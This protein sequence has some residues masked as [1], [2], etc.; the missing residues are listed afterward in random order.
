MFR[1]AASEF[2]YVRTYSRWL[3]EQGRRENWPETVDRFVNFIVEERGALIPPKVLRK[4][5]QKILNF[6]VMP[7]MRALWA[8]G[9]AAKQ[10]NVCMYNC[11]ALAVDS[12]DAFA[13]T[14]YI[15][16]CG[17][18]L[19]YSVQ[20]K[21]ISKLPEI[22][23]IGFETL[24]RHIVEDSKDGWSESIRLLMSSLYEGKDIEFDYTSIRPAG[25]KLKT[26]G[27]RA[28]GPEPLMSLHRFIRDTFTVAQG[29]KLTSIECSDIMNKIAE[30]VVVGG[31]RRSSQ[32][33][34]S[35]LDDAEMRNAKNWP[36]PL[37]R[38]MSNNSAIYESKPSAVDF[39]KEWANLAASGTGE[40]G[41]FNLYSVRENAPIRRNKDKIELTNPCVTGDTLVAVAD[42]RD[43]ISFE[44]LAKEG[45]DVPVFCLDDNKKPTIRMMRNPRI[46]GHKVPIYRICLDDGSVI[47]STSNHKFLLKNGNY[48]EAEKLKNGDS[49]LIMGKRQEPNPVK[50]YWRIQCNSHNLAEHRMIASFFNS[51]EIPSEYDVH[52]K[53]ENGLNNAIDNLEI[54]KK[55]EHSKEHGENSIG[56]L[57][58]RWS[59]H[60][61][62]EIYLHILKLTK[63]LGRRVITADW[64]EYAPK[65][66]LPLSFSEFRLTTLGSLKNLFERAANELG[67]ENVKERKLIDPR[68]R[69]L[70]RDLVKQGYEMEVEDGRIVILKEC[71]SCHIEIRLPVTSREVTYCSTT[72]INKERSN[73]SYRL[74]G[75]KI[76]AKAKIK[77]I[78]IK[79]KQ[80]EV[81]KRLQESLNRIPKKKEWINRCKE[82]GVSPEISRKSSPFQSWNDLLSAAENHNHKVL[83]V[84]LCGYEDVY[85]GTVDNFHNYFIGGFIGSSNKIDRKKFLYVNTLN[86]GEVALRNKSFCNLSEVV[87]RPEDDLDSLLE[88]VETATWLGVIQSTFIDFPFLRKEWIDNCEEERLLG[89]SLTGQMDNKKLMSADALKALKQ[90]ALKVAKHASQKMGINMSAAVTLTKPSGTVS[91]V[92]DSASGLHTRYAPFYIRR[93]RI[94]AQDPLC[95][96]IRDQGIKLY[97]EVGQENLSEERVTTWVIE[98]PMKSPEGSVTR[99]DLTALDQL[100]WYKNIQTNWCEHNAS[101]TIYVAENDWLEVG[102]WVYK[103]W[104]IVNGISFLPYDGGKY[105]LAPY[106]QITEEKY[107]KMI[108]NFKPID[109]SKLS[110]YET[111]DNTE[112][113]KSLACA[114]GSCEI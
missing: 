38:S 58:G 65:Y 107:N 47:R 89:V 43:H 9:P 16:C 63:N 114:G 77:H 110:G 92:V 78:H 19:G 12:I 71:C 99:E 52:H 85:N 56:E 1:N 35:D 57:N 20:D 11:S 13:E 22:A 49:L 10:S 82:L 28:S 102:N 66:T 96:M 45:K 6:E 106:E 95:K 86:C 59:G 54:L 37:H 98:F 17:A 94:S 4:I 84:E 18:G 24:G 30:I 69:T 42:G 50:L 90:K 36:F 101:T 33:S 25:A 83:F 113:A 8:A 112:G 87:V 108:K 40:R 53:D 62:D 91:Q 103:N 104:D 39:L 97:P 75:E 74:S 26:M 73:E 48:V 7:S 68:R 21:F 61:N 70:Y 79:T 46:T 23:K 81:F 93:Y 31:V 51:V 27:G 41:I 88:K 72:C 60:S 15:L 29:R 5:K 105:K 3:E 76:R 80:I 109:Y 64:L 44:Q 55:G 14:L 67:I 32:I 100:E 111:E 34:L 2:V